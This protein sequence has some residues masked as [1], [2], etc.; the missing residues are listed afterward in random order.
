PGRTR[1]G[2]WWIP[3]LR[4]RPGDARYAAATT[5]PRAGRAS[6][7]PFARADPDGLAGRERHVLLL[8]REAVARVVA[9]RA[10]SGSS[11]SKR[12]R[13]SG[14]GGDQQRQGRFERSG[15]ALGPGLIG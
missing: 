14:L 12:R 3:G 13:R 10:R 8:R 9:A 4:P 5:T 11:G 2:P 1:G 7:R 6:R 15:L